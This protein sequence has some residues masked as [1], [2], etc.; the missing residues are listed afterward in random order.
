MRFT[1]K[2]TG[3]DTRHCPGNDNIMK[4]NDLDEYKKN[5]FMEMRHPLLQL[6]N[7]QHV[8]FFINKV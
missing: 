3:W 8:P 1:I 7:H 2:S 5:I 6:S 4:S